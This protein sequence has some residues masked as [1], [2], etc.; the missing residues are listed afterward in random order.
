MQQSRTGYELKVSVTAVSSTQAKPGGEQSGNEV[1]PDAG[2]R[3]GESKKR[4]KVSNCFLW[5][6][7][8]RCLLWQSRPKPQSSESEWETWSQSILAPF[9]SNPLTMSSPYPTKHNVFPISG[10]MLYAS[11]GSFSSIPSPCQKRFKPMKWDLHKQ[12]LVACLHHLQYWHAILNKK[13]VSGEIDGF[14]LSL[15]AKHNRF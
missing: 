15:T 7:I 1:S 4:A 3:A 10:N 11:G 12:S 2:D 9:L 14:Y 13:L 6:G 8:W 5:G